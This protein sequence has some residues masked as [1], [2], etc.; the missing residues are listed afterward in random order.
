MGI[1]CHGTNWL[2]EEQ[3][4]NPLSIPQ[5]TFS[6]L[7]ANLFAQFIDHITKSTKWSGP[8]L[9]SV[10]EDVRAIRIPMYNANVVL[11]DTP[12]FETTNRSDVVILELIGEW[13]KKT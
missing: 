10:T 2:R 3:C 7:I 13:L 11:V 6:W 5:R 8:T 4:K 12:G 1:Q 9:Q